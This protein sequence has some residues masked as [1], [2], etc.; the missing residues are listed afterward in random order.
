MKINE[1]T[2]ISQ[3][4]DRYIP[5]RRGEIDS[6]QRRIVLCFLSLLVRQFGRSWKISHQALV[7]HVVNGSTLQELGKVP[8]VSKGFVATVLSDGSAPIQIGGIFR[9]A[10]LTKM[11]HILDKD[12]R[13]IDRGALLA[14]QIALFGK[15][16][17]PALGLVKTR[18]RQIQWP[19]HNGHQ[20]K[21]FVSEFGHHA[22]DLAEEPVLSS[23]LGFS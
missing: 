10:F 2:E 5:Q 11:L 9:L 7:Q 20:S 6:D 4:I 16:S 21:P 14:L 12:V 1:S 18:G 19:P 3:G 13:Q 17:D 8:T 23:P 22:L 15:A